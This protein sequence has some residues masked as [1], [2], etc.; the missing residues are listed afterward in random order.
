[1]SFEI[2]DDPNY[3]RGWLTGRIH[4]IDQHLAQIRKGR[5]FRSRRKLLL[6]ERRRWM[7]ELAALLLAR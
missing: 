3:R 6:A 4:V 7:T 1:M 2:R 5:G